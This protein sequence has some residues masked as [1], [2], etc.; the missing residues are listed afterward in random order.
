MKKD[1]KIDKKPQHQQYPVSEFN[2]KTIN[3]GNYG[4][5]NEGGFVKLL[6][7]TPPKKPT[8]KK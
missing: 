4:D 7:K 1:K 8:P 5:H 6:T 2:I 3:P